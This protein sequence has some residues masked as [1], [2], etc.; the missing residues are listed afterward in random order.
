MA[1]A[2]PGTTPETIGPYRVL[3]VLGESQTCRVLLAQQPEP[4]SRRVVLKVIKPGVTSQ[5]DAA[6]FATERRA[7]QRM[8]HPGI[9]SVL[10]AAATDDGSPYFAM[11]HVDGIA[12]ADYCDRHTLSIPQRLA[13]FSQVCHAV[14]HIHD[15]GFI[16]CDIK[17]ANVLVTSSAGGATAKII[18]FG[19][20]RP[21]V[22]SAADKASSI[23]PDEFLGTPSYA[24]PEQTVAADRDI[25]ARCD[26]Y[27]LGVLLY[28]L[29]TGELP[30][31]PTS[32]RGPSALFMTVV[33]AVA[34]QLSVFRRK[35][36]VGEARKGRPAGV[37]DACASVET[38]IA[39]EAL[40]EAAFDQVLFMIREFDAPRPSRRLRATAETGEKIA[41]TAAPKRRTTTRALAR[42]LRGK[43]DW[44]TMKAME[45]DRSRRYATAVAFAED[46][47]RYTD[48]AAV[49][50]RP[51]SPVQRGVRF[52]RHNK[53]LLS[54]AIRSVRRDRR[55]TVA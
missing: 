28:E 34:V 13:I 8:T 55:G 9:V 46:I 25:D 33:T 49:S 30:I 11:E 45:K 2:E 26:V 51:A 43:L 36:R 14:Q 5:R 32:M 27:S 6:R 35:K 24:S 42:E 40:D 16:H 22:L 4:M 10:D 47:E 29:L 23:E 15:H 7:I 31:G 18:D 53:A 52:I 21:I 20:T 37:T 19:A 1:K 54:W 44:I 39:K 3:G 38:A 48:N 17:S 41:T 50:A 12:L